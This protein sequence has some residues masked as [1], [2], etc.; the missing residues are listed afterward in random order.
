MVSAALFGI[1]ENYIKACHSDYKL[2]CP[3]KIGYFDNKQ[4]WPQILTMK[5]TEIAGS[6]SGLELVI[7]L[8]LAKGMQ[9]NIT[10]LK[11]EQ[12]P[13]KIPH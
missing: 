6:L 9:I 5:S 10:F 12:K 11:T 7:I 1:L 8:E 3:Y 13:P 2:V 4:H